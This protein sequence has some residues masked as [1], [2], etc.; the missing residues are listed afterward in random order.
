MISAVEI[1]KLN[2]ALLAN[3]SEKETANCLIKRLFGCLG[4][5]NAIKDPLIH[6]KAILKTV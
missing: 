2:N 4:N 6:K 3:S 1:Q 5:V